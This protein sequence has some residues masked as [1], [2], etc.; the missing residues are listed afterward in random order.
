MEIRIVLLLAFVSIALITNTLLFWLAYKALSGFTAKVTETVSLFANSS[1]RMEWL[2][3]LGSAS[4][5]AI[6]LTETAKVRMAESRPI[7]EKT[8]QDYKV[9]LKRVDSTLETVE[10]EVAAN[11]RK[12]RDVVREPAFSF[13]SFVAG[14]IQKIQNFQ[15]EE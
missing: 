15:T 10:R 13:V 7:V 6:A 5:K 3:A 11:A 14:L 12:A 2:N 4:E 1:E 8:L 9:V